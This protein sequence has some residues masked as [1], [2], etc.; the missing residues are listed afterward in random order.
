MQTV[1]PAEVRKLFEKIPSRRVVFQFPDIKKTPIYHSFRSL[2]TEDFLTKINLSKIHALFRSEKKTLQETLLSSPNVPSKIHFLKDREFT[3][4]FLKK[5]LQ[6]LPWILVL[7]AGC[8][9]FGKELKTA[10]PALAPYSVSMGSSLHEDILLK[11]EKTIRRLNAEV[12]TTSRK[13]QNSRKILDD[14]KSRE[15]DYR[16]EILRISLRY[17]QEI[18]TLRRSLEAQEAILENLENEAETAK[19][20]GAKIN[21]KT[22]PPEMTTDRNPAE[23]SP[24]LLEGK[25]VMVNSRYEF[26]VIDNGARSGVRP[27]QE[28]LV[29]RYGSLTVLGFVEEVYPGVSGVSVKDGAFLL[30]LKEGDPVRVRVS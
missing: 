27:G 16:D 3:D 14:A 8:L 25:V 26:V 2:F 9:F 29:P 5:I 23:V 22:A 15:A 17:Q 1:R 19:L 30:E 24:Q 13:I 10:D 28:V 20:I 7:V 18:D 6:G 11:Q 4:R 12:L 21:E